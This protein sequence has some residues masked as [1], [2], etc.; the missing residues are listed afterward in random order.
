[1]QTANIATSIITAVL[2]VYMHNTPVYYTTGSA[3]GQDEA[4][5]VFWLAI[6]VGKMVLSCLL[7]IA[8]FV[9]AKA[10]IF[11][12]VIFSVPILINPILT[13]SV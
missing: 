2:V 12:G 10:K 11:F 7:G 5:P 1:M 8:G 6:Q 3:S 4:N 13:C 9:P